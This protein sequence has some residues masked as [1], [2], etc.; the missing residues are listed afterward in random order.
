MD[1]PIINRELRSHASTPP[2]P[3]AMKLLGT[4]LAQRAT[5]EFLWL[6]RDAS[7][8]RMSFM[9]SGKAWVS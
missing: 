5:L 9:S 8:V 7:L 3:P 2:S 1:K 4:S 6:C